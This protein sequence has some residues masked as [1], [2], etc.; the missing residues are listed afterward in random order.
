MLPS[1][2]LRHMDRFLRPG[3]DCQYHSIPT[4]HLADMT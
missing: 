3:L 2:C 4:T 1:P